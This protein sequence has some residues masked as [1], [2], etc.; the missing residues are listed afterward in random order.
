MDILRQRE[1]TD[2]ELQAAGFQY[3]RPVKRLVMAK[4]LFDTKDIDIKV[5][6][7]TGNIGDFLCYYPGTEVRA[8]PDEYDHWPVR[9]DIFFKTYKPW[10]K[11]DWEPNAPEKHLMDLGCLPYYKDLGVWAQRLHTSRQV[12]SLESPDPVAIPAGRWLLIGSHGEPYSTTDEEFRRR[13]IVPQETVKERMY[14][15]A[16]SSAANRNQDDD[17]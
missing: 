6:T 10:P 13:Y 11:T 16:I 5:E 8:N 14:W 1:W 9:R 12:Q 15:A 17:T 2:E 7:I 4:L 3:F